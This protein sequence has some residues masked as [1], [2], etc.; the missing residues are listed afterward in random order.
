MRASERAYASLRE[1]IVGWRLPPG[2]VLAEVEQSERLG[3]SRTPLREALGR[4]VADGL[5]A[6]L[7]GRGL[8]VTAVSL[9]D[10]TAL[11]E[12]RQAL[13][14]EAARL[15][16][17]RRDPEVFRALREEFRDAAELPRGT[18]PGRVRYYEL[19]ARFDGAMDA[20]AANP[21]LVGALRTLRPHL[22]RIRRVS[23]DNLDRLHAA[24]REHLLIVDAVLAGDA[25]LAAAATRV[26]LHQS[27]RSV[28]ASA[29]RL[30]AAS[31]STEGQ[32]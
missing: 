24:A 25:D 31:P 18:D 29:E 11:F 16:A 9:A 21:Y 2:S 20:A 12:L 13:E 8:V 4:L 5:V 17:A 1:D 22:A 30:T 26:H 32:S 7:G 19:V 6:Q 14:Q 27:L 10:V 15:A 28:L 23:K 3:V